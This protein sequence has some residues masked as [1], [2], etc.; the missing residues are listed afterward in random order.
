[1]SAVVVIS[2]VL[3]LTVLLFFALRAG[4]KLIDRSLVDSQFRRRYLIG[5]LVVLLLWQFANGLIKRHEQRE[6]LAHLSLVRRVEPVYSALAKQA[7]IEGMVQFDAVIN[8]SGRVEKLDLISGHPMLIAAAKDA[9]LQWQYS[10]LP[11]PVHT[12][13]QVNFVLKPPS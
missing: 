10:K 7:R 12:I 1:L 5:A 13:I 6:M 9:I 4:G 8:A 11:F 3:G 2:V